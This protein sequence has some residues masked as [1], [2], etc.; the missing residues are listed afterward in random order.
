MADL[1][2]A[3]DFDLDVAV[4]VGGAAR[5]GV[6]AEAVLRAEFAIDAI[7]DAVEFLELIG[8]EHGAAHGVGDGV[9]RVLA[10]GVAA[11]FVFHRAH[12]DRI[13]QR[14]G[15]HGGFAC[16]GCSYFCCRFSDAEKSASCFL[17]HSSA[18]TSRRKRKSHGVLFF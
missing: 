13:E 10:G 6:V 18:R 14:A 3:V 11:A 9:E 1:V 5:F 2:G 7:E 16:S 17:Q 15:L 12:D 8:I 4:G